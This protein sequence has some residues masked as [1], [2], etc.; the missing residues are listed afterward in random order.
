[1]EPVLSFET[2]T[3][4]PFPLGRV[5]IIGFV[6]SLTSVLDFVYCKIAQDSNDTGNVPLNIIVSSVA[7]MNLLTIKGDLGT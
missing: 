4:T 2:T 5:F 6:R 7:V 3:S 1:M